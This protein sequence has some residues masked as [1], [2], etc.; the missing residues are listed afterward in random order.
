MYV[1]M[2]P[3]LKLCVLLLILLGLGG[4]QS[5]IYFYFYFLLIDPPILC[6]GIKCCLVLIFLFFGVSEWF[7]CGK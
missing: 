2:D 1:C 7:F 6:L 5:F 4:Y 3:A